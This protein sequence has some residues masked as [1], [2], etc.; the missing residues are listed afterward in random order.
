MKHQPDKYMQFRDIVD[1][2][3]PEMS[4]IFALGFVW[5]GTGEN[6]LDVNNLDPNRLVQQ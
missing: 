4:N 2:I 1:D 6:S 3:A 5:V